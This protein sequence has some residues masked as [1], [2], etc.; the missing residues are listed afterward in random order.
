MTAIRAQ[1]RLLLLSVLVGVALVASTSL[2]AAAPYLSHG[3]GGPGTSSGAPQWGSNQSKY[4][5]T[6]SESGLPTGTN[7]S[8]HLGNGWFAWHSVFNGTNNSTIGFLVHNGTIGFSIGSVT[9]SGGSLYVPSPAVGNVT[10]NGTNVTV[11]VTFAAVHLYGLTF[12]ETGLPN[13]TWWFAEIYNASTGRL[14]NSS[15]GPSIAFT[16]PN[17][18]YAFTVG[19]NSFYPT[20]A[21]TVPSWNNTTANGSGPSPPYTPTPSSGNVTVSGENATVAIGFAPLTFYTLTFD[22]TGLPTGAFWSVALSGGYVGWGGRGFSP[23]SLTPSCFGISGWNGSA[24]STIGFTLPD[25]TYGFAVG[26]VTTHGSIFVPVPSA[27]SV[28]VNGTNVTVN[29]A[30]TAVPLYNLTFSE[31]GLP[32]GT[33][34]YVTLYSNSTGWQ[35]NSTTNSSIGFAVPDGTYAFTVGTASFWASPEAVAPFWNNSSGGGLGFGGPYTATPGSG[36]VTV[37]GAGV[38][39]GITFAP[40]T[41]YTVMFNETGLPNGTFWSVGLFGAA[42]GFGTWSGAETPA[43][44]GSPSWNGSDTSTAGFTVPNGTY[45]FSVSPV[46]TP[47]GT[48]VPTPSSGNV[49]V[50]GS[51]VTVDISFAPIAY[52]TVTFNET[53]LPNGT[54]WWVGLYGGYS[55]G[56]GPNG[57]GPTP[58]CGVITPGNRTNGTQIGFTVPDGTYAFFVGSANT[59]NGTY[60]PTP[61]P[62]NVTVDG[63][64]VTVTITFAATENPLA[65]G[66]HPPAGAAVHLGG[67]SLSVGLLAEFAGVLAL[68]GGAIALIA[69]R[70]TK[71]SQ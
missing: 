58:L 37:D 5:L 47:D 44:G 8:V 7:W 28:T 41:F 16:V 3:S 46:W 10:V 13:G 30:F 56:W 4:D 29:V 57:S 50:N 12:T 18:T 36:N 22:E 48:Y 33:W 66:A 49:T 67:L 63:A 19:T 25:G 21:T 64:N 51:S 40:L 39:V 45:D 23:G 55:G 32:N 38:V 60:T 43:C 2:A 68:V 71:R 6:F 54:F 53:G 52:Y 27:G 59:S 17:G 15:Q 11:D 26:N 61:Q 1:R 31:S 24:N 14:F 9:T 34:W 69:R 65:S 35:F 70:L 20:P 62:G 42:F